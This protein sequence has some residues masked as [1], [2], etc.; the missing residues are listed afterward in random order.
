M[1]TVYNFAPIITLVHQCVPAWCFLWTNVHKINVWPPPLVKPPIHTPS[2]AISA[3]WLVLER[4]YFEF[5]KKVEHGQVHA[6]VLFFYI[7]Q[8][9]CGFQVPE[10]NFPSIMFELICS[11]L[12]EEE[13]SAPKVSCA[14]PSLSTWL[15]SKSQF[16]SQHRHHLSLSVSKEHLRTEVTKQCSPDQGGSGTK[17]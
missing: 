16:Q 12:L 1:C 4:L 17:F 9:C 14:L 8:Y 7:N 5:H 11:Q 3:N 2:C 6:R 10:A 15:Q 13:Q